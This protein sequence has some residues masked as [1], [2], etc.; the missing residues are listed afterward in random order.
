MHISNNSI[1]RQQHKQHNIV[2]QHGDVKQI[3]IV[4][5]HKRI[6]HITDHPHIKQHDITIA[7]HII[8]CAHT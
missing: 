8:G 4:A 7:Q 1:D 5:Q 6:V 2:I 3:T